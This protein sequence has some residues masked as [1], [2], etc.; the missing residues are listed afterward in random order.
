MEKLPTNTVLKPNGWI[1][2]KSVG[3]FLNSFSF[4]E[5][6]TKHTLSIALKRLVMCSSNTKKQNQKFIAI[7]HNEPRIG[8]V[9]F[10]TY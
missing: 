9:L 8:E 3:H 5:P 7:A 6:A 2:P 10:T 1:Q 4:T